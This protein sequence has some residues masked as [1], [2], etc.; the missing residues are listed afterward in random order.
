MADD[1]AANAN[2][3]Q[4]QG[5]QAGA[6]GQQGT[7]AGAPGGNAG[8]NGAAQRWDAGIDQTIRDFWAAKKYD[9]SDPTKLVDVVTRN[10][11]NAEKFLGAPADE[12]LRIPKPNAETAEITNFWNRIGV[13]K[14]AKDYD[15][16]AIKMAD[17]SDVDPAFVDTMRASLHAN[18]VPKDFAGNV[19]KDVIKY[20]EQNDKTEAETVTAEAQRQNQEL[21]KNWGNRKAYNMTV[22][23]DA[24]DRVGQAAGLT[25]EQINQGWDALSKVGGIGASYAL[26][27]LRIIGSRMGEAP[28]VNSTNPPGDRNAVS[29][30]DAKAQLDELK[31]DQAFMNRYL[32]GDVD[33]NRRMRNLHQIMT[34]VQTTAA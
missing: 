33:A 20:L 14:E 11:Q 5:G 21:D 29:K 15:F 4:S 19:V 34:G 32:S 6:A 22:A 10:Y 26:E 9:V 17:G 27:M 30:E 25:Q 31:R 23:K 16:S 8:A 12:L 1:A 7:G 3:G 18:R 13:P 2:A 24:L 28:F